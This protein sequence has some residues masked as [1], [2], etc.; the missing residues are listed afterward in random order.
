[1]DVG[2]KER[3]DP[4]MH[5]RLLTGT[6]GRLALPSSEM[7]RTVDGAAAAGPPLTCLRALSTEVTHDVWMD[8]SNSP[9]GTHWW[10]G[11]QGVCLQDGSACGGGW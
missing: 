2:S 3:E 7:R 4:R 10:L 8:Y 11:G 9:R 1:M 5:S 6:I